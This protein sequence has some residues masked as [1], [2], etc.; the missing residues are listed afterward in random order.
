MWH[1][2]QYDKIFIFI[3][4]GILGVLEYG[5]KSK[6]FL[7][8]WS[9]K[10][11]FLVWREKYIFIEYGEKTQFIIGSDLF[12]QTVQNCRNM[13]VHFFQIRNYKDLNFGIYIAEWVIW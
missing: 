2:Q 12:L 9:E 10:H 13:R 6:N 5:E 1:V 4:S 8:V 11:N 7:R 3:D